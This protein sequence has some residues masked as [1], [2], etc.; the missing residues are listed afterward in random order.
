MSI[1]VIN[2]GYGYWGVQASIEYD[3]LEYKVEDQSYQ[4]PQVDSW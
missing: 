4:R 2:E 3:G 1:S